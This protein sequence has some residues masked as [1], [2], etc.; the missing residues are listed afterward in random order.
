M[1]ASS[2]QAARDHLAI[3]ASASLPPLTAP[4]RPTHPAYPSPYSPVPGTPQH[5]VHTNPPSPS[6]KSAQPELRR[7]VNRSL[8]PNNTSSANLRSHSQPARPVPMA[9]TVPN[10]NALLLGGYSLQQYQQ[11]RQQQLYN[12]L[13]SHKRLRNP[14]TSNQGLLHMDPRFDENLPKEYVGYYVH[15]PPASRGY[16]NEFGASH[17]PLFG[18]AP[19]RSR[20]LPHGFS[21]FDDPSRSPSPSP[22]V[23]YRDRSTSV[24]SAASAPPGPPHRER[25]SIPHSNLRTS[26]PIIVDGS[27]GWPPYD[28]PTERVMAPDIYT[29]LRGQA[30][31]SRPVIGEEPVQRPGRSET[32]SSMPSRQQERSSMS[33]DLPGAPNSS[34]TP[35]SSV[36]PRRIYP[37]VNGTAPAPIAAQMES[38]PGNGY[39]SGVDSS[40]KTIDGATP[41]PHRNVSAKGTPQSL[42]APKEDPNPNEPDVLLDKPPKPL[43]LLSPVREVRT[44]SPSAIRK[45]D[46]GSLGLQPTNRLA[47]KY[48][49][50][51]IPPFSGKA[52]LGQKDTKGSPLSPKPNGLPAVSAVSA[53]TLQSST[54]GWQQTTSKKNKKH[55]KPKANGSQSTSV[56]SLEPMPVNESDR[57]GG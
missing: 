5:S 55:N 38:N 9:L 26:G 36:K 17:V 28:Q 43:P 37:Q 41:S 4:L 31:S 6:M 39:D 35:S 12:I 34:F 19:Y 52:G 57:K 10:P 14:E 8:H 45:D 22:A 51:E 15:D 2:Q 50:Q 20:G 44:P 16:H 32:V 53:Q 11:M 29:R 54:N 27:D 24:M 7:S 13:E 46:D 33:N 3:S 56:A 21:R 18:E 1:S 49:L 25:P 23:P 30:H 47:R 48:Q 40:Q 42:S